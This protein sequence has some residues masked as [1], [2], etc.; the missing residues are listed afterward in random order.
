MNNVLV[1][2]D[3]QIYVQSCYLDND[4]IKANIGINIDRYS[5]YISYY[6]R[7][8]VSSQLKLE[9]EYDERDFYGDHKLAQEYIKLIEDNLAGLYELLIKLSAKD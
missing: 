1:V 4:K 9:Y 6:F 8:S 3:D 5:K 2:N 7:V